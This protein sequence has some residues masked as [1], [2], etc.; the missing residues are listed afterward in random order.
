MT[1]HFLKTVFI[2][3][4]VF[5][6]LLITDAANAY[7]IDG[8]EETGIKRLEYYR[9]SDTGEIKGKTLQPGA[10]DRKKVEAVNTIAS[11]EIQYCF[12][13]FNGSRCSYLCRA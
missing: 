9:L 3:S 10:V 12:A 2:T 11:M 8:Y 7:P 4:I 1:T 6:A 5:N 13:R